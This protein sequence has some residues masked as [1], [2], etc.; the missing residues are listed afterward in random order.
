MYV[1][2]VASFDG[3]RAGLLATYELLSLAQVD[4]EVHRQLA[5]QLALT[6]SMLARAF[7]GDAVSVEEA[8]LLRRGSAY[9][10]VL[11]GLMTQWLVSPEVVT[12]GVD[13][14]RVLQIAEDAGG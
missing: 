8:E 6:D 11:G 2:V 3:H 7:D 13:V 4:I 9:Y 1:P 10:T 5:T 14:V 12:P